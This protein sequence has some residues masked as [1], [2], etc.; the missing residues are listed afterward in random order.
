VKAPAAR[1]KVLVLLAGS[2]W[3]AVGGILV[4]VAVR[5]SVTLRGHT[6][7]ALLIGLAGGV[8]VFRFGFSRLAAM[9][10]SRIYTQAPGKDRVCVFAFQ[11]TRSYL[12]VAV[13]MAMGYGLRH[14][15]IPKIDLIPI[16][17]A[18]GLGLVLSSLHYYRRLLHNK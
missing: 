10:L 13:M 7:V 5:W 8:V 4:A 1:R 12:I 3:T 17:L 11:N 9:N 18:I 16:Y 2:V 6:A 14:S 15:P